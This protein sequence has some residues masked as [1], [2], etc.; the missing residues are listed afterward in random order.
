[1]VTGLHAVGQPLAVVCA[2]DL[3]FVTPDLLRDL[4]GGLGAASAEVDAVVPLS[5]G[6]RQPLL[7]AYRTRA[8]GSLEQIFAGGERSISVALDRLTVEEH[9]LGAEHVT[10]ALDVDTPEDLA[11]ARFRAGDAIS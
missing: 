4:T 7:A 9:A 10:A 11:G 8:A 6:R 2:C 1:V 5:E 3:P